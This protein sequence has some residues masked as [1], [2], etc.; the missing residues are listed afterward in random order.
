MIGRL[1]GVIAEKA[2]P[3]VLID[4]QGV[5]YEVD[6]PM[7]TF[8]NLPNLGERVTL[9][10][11]FVVREDAQI[12]FGFGT[13]AE[14]DT[15]RQLIRISGVG[16]RTALAILSGLSVS[17]LA[18]AVSL[19]EA[20]RLVKVPGIGKKTAERLLLELKGKLGPDLAQPAAALNDAQAD[21]LQALVAL[22]YSEKEA[23]AALKALP[24]DVGVSD[25]IKLALKA[26]TR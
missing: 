8:Y 14:R 2:P 22:G 10:T 15:F 7:S 5:G 9:L 24:P 21:V 18:Q 12:L 6:V 16:P 20:G 4:V 3:Q 1:T 11:H 17:D 13:A 26:L 23:A 19:Q 25:G